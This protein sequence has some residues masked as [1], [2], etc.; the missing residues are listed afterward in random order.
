M[1]G[2]ILG[3]KFW[4]LTC[5]KLVAEL[6]VQN[7]FAIYNKLFSMYSVSAPYLQRSVTRPSAVYLETRAIFADTRKIKH[8]LA[9]QNTQIRLFLSFGKKHQL[10]NFIRNRTTLNFLTL[11]NFFSESF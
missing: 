9:K 2:A 7:L 10:A 1:F 4:G 3:Q 5:M 8:K 11:K 6:T